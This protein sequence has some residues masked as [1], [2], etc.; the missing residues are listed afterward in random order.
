ML[1]YRAHVP[2]AF[3]NVILSD[4]AVN[5]AKDRELEQ[6]LPFIAPPPPPIKQD[7][8]NMVRIKGGTCVIGPDDEDPTG[9]SPRG[10]V[11]MPD[12]FI[13]RYE[14][15]IGEYAKF[16]NAG[17]HD[18]FWW[19]DMADPNWCGIVKKG[20]GKYETV[21]GKELYPVVLLKVDGAK[22]Y[23]EWA[24]KRLPTEYEWE[25]AARGGSE[26]LYPWGNEPP[27]DTRAN[28]N[29]RIGH[30]TPVGSY[31]RGRTPE[32]LY[33][34]AGNVDEMIDA[35]WAEYPWGKQISGNDIVCPVARG[36][37][38]TA[39]WF[40]LKTTHRDTVKSHFMAPM[41]G[42]RCAKNAQ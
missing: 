7:I 36:G 22:A 34:M 39:P 33:D 5:R 15:T 42:F 24:G 1:T 20:D 31:P 40:K 32:G 6:A 25:I 19:P 11:T 29:F 18:V 38:W 17:G 30:T 41:V 12:F 13:D 28:Y 21:P 10:A 26:R 9:A 8:G 14:V 4:R 2:E 27:D 3:G 35:L 37:A 16:L 23:A